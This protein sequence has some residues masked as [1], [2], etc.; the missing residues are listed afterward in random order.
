LDK[1]PLSEVTSIQIELAFMDVIEKR[2]LSESYASNLFG[3]IK[4][5]FEYAFRNRYI[6]TNEFLY[7]DKDRVLAFVNEDIFQRIRT[8]GIESEFVFARENGERYTTLDISCACNRRG[9]EAGIEKVCIHR[10]RRTVASELRKIYD[11]KTVASLLGHLE[12]TDEAYYH[13]DNSEEVVKIEASNTL[14]S[15]LMI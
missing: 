1:T 13:Y 6:S 4:N 8:L 11:I 2:N 15:N 9:E 3:Y 14:Y 12:E 5:A 10:I 7:V